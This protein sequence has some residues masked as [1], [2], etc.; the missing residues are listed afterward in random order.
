MIRRKIIQLKNITQVPTKI[1]RGY[2]LDLLAQL[3]ISCFLPLFSGFKVS[4]YSKED[5]EKRYSLSIYYFASNAKIFFYM[6]SYYSIIFF[7][8]FQNQ[9][10]P[11]KYK[12][13]LHVMFLEKYIVNGPSQ[14]P[15][16]P[17]KKK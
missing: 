13:I 12:N 15:P 17:A 3:S 10:F 11:I 1:F 8:S 6:Y 16:G 5:N 2:M 7:P 4:K 14:N 9:P